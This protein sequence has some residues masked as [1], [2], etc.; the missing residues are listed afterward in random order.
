MLGNLWEYCMGPFAPDQPGRA[1]LRGG[2][3]ETPE[4]GITPQ[5]RLGFD[6]DWVLADPNVPAGVWWVPDGNHLGFRVL[7]EASK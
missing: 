5:S 4:A 1:V 3:W 7:C 2:S 6:D